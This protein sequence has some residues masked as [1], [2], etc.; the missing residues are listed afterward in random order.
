M[1]TTDSSRPAVVPFGARL[2]RAM[3][4][5]GPLCVGIDPHPGLLEAWGL[6]DSA[7]GLRDF[8]LR[9]VEALEGRVAAVKPQSAFFERHG[10]AGLAVLEEI[11]A[12]LRDCGLL[13]ILDVKRGDIG[14]TMGAYAQAYLADGAPLSCD[15]MTV[16]PYLG[17]GSLAPALDL[18][19]GTGR[20]LFVLALTS[21]PEGATVQHARTAQGAAVAASVARG[22]SRSNDAARGA[23]V[24]GSIG[25]VVGATVG[26][27][28]A[29]LGIDLV[30][31][32]GPLLAPGVGTQGAGAAEL[33]EVFGP[34]RGQVLAS[35][36]RAVLSAGPERSALRRAAE[37]ARTQAAQALRP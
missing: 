25:L 28:V 3:D 34:A 16:S 20:G 11:L 26:R 14:S 2:S 37:A 27:A 36:S 18:A 1:T 21:N 29:D 33:A 4:D 13:S 30:A 7:A 12:A 32:N 19:A 15:A 6:T 23:G 17:Y 10:S 8:G 5:D 9:T 22:V 35:T 24:L 31:V